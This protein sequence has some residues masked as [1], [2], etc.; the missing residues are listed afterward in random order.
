[1][2]INRILKVSRMEPVDE[3]LN[4]RKVREIISPGAT[5]LQLTL[6]IFEISL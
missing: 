2:S 5:C 3:Q 1:M 4:L 6:I